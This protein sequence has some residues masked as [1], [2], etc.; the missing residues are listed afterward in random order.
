M[1]LS[2]YKCM[3]IQIQNSESSTQ[4]LQSYSSN[5]SSNR[6]K[7]QVILLQLETDYFSKLFISE[8]AP[9]QAVALQSSQ[10]LPELLFYMKKSY[11]ILQLQ[12]YKGTHSSTYNLHV[13]HYTTVYPEN[14]PSRIQFYMQK[15]KSSS[16]TT[17]TYRGQRDLHS[18]K[19][20]LCIEGKE[21]F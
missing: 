3:H 2:N 12:F 19:E 17:T 7:I 5:V 6:I 15:T 10:R 16:S 13:H 21:I 11:R 1:V 20:I 8:K 4:G 18:R 9:F 14:S